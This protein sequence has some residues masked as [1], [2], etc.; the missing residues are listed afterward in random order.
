MPPLF[1]HLNTVRRVLQRRP[2]ALFTDFDGTVSEIVS[3][4]GDARISPVC[5]RHLISLCEKLDLTAI[6]SGRPVEL[7]ARL[8]DVP[9]AVYV[10]NHGLEKMVDGE[11]VSRQNVGDSTASVKEVIGSVQR[12]FD[13]IEGVVIEDKGPVVAVHYRQARDPA[14][15][16]TA[17]LEL[18]EGRKGV[19]IGQGKM[20]IEVR[21]AVEFSKGLAVRDLIAE[22]RLRGGIYMGDDLTDVDA[23]R[24]L[25]QSA[26]GS[27]FSG[28]G[29]AVT[30]T[31]TPPELIEASDFTLDGLEEV[32]RFLGWLDDELR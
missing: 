28:V 30:G 24:Q 17:I 8:C 14:E 12:Q 32:E 15:A 27:C 25:K 5:R 11:V 3:S 10:G 29:I 26:I 18:L 16:E 19:T 21:P 9:G 7:L 22:R 6:V 23:L 2:L 31:E 20:V 4:P 1:Q 13:R